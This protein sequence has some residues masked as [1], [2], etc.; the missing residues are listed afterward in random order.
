MRYFLRI[1]LV[2]LI[3]VAVV[4]GMYRFTDGKDTSSGDN[5]I[6]TATKA[7]A[8][9]KGSDRILLAHQEYG[10]DV[11]DLYLQDNNTIFVHNGKEFVY[12]NWSKYI[13]VEAPEMYVGDFNRDSVVDDV[14]LRVAGSVNSETG[15]YIYQIYVLS[16]AID[17]DGNEVYKLNVC[18]ERTWKDKFNVEI[19]LE[20]S[21]MSSC[22]KIIQL[23]MSAKYRDS[24]I[25]YD[26]ETGAVDGDYIK[27]IAA[28]RNDEGGY[29]N[30]DRWKYGE[31][32]YYINEDN[33]ITVDTDVFVYYKDTT[34]IQNIGKLQCKLYLNSVNSFSFIPRSIIFKQNPKYRAS[35][36]KPGD[37]APWKYTETNYSTYSNI[38]GDTV[39]DWLTYEFTYNPEVSERSTSYANEGTEMRNISKFELTE[40]YLK[41]Y[42]K[43]GY[44]F[45][46]IPAQKGDYRVFINPDNEDLKYD[47]SMSATVEQVD[48]V[49]VLTIMFD[50][51]YFADEPE[52]IKICYNTDL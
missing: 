46:D 36:R 8:T 9:E 35:S 47:I 20:I 5:T 13:A 2:I 15:G 33:E 26:Q 21:Q 3:C 48:G 7:P 27:Y 24:D 1:L 52:Y 39:I 22:K 51:A 16:P 10:E 12:D 23:A 18:N 45:S 30:T 44:T 19:S 49:D 37:G 38:Q 42:A 34:E 28:L 41:L 32:V 4:F 50:K 25:T 14:A 40:S 43:E 6:T 29:Y 17:D 31:S 11:Y